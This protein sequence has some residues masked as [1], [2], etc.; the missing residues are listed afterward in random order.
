[1]HHLL[2][3]PV[4]NALTSRD[5]HLGSGAGNVRYFDAEVSPFGGFPTGYAE[6]F[7]ELYD[8]LPP[9]RKMLYASTTAIDEPAH[10]KTVAY[11]KGS[12][13]VFDKPRDV[14]PLDLQP[15]PLT[16]DHVDEMVQLAAL[17][18]P[19]PFDKRTIEFGH[20][21]GFFENEKLIAMTG[22]RLHPEGYSEISAV[23][24]HPRALGKGY[25]T[26]LIQQQL[27]LISRDGNIPFLH[28]REDNARA[29]AVY[30]RLGFRLRGPMH[31]YFM[32]R[33][34]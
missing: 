13:F 27:E 17:T 18:K 24:T 30:E 11:I 14:A 16:T 1:M 10:W 6:G 29:I 7:A 34:D 23:C 26:T 8:Q 28:V 15:V 20:Y 4:F 9:G 31:F 3:N 22:Q 33:M 21:F 2:D 25:A 5:A 19:G 12:Q 32:R